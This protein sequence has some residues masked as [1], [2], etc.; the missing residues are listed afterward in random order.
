MNEN[1]TE[2]DVK[3]KDVKKKDVNRNNDS[4]LP[5]YKIPGNHYEFLSY[6][7]KKN[8]LG[9][10][11]TKF[12]FNIINPKISQIKYNVSLY[13]INQFNEEIFVK[14]FH[15]ISERPKSSTKRN[16]KRF[17]NSNFKGWPGKHNSQDYIN[18]STRNI[19]SL[20]TDTSTVDVSST[21]SEQPP[22]GS[23]QTWGTN[24]CFT[25]QILS[26][27]IGSGTAAIIQCTTSLTTILV[28]NMITFTGGWNY[29]IT[30][31]GISVPGAVNG[32]TSMTTI[33]SITLPYTITVLNPYSFY[34]CSNLKT[35]DSFN[36]SGVIVS[37]ILPSYI[38]S[39]CEYSFAAC[40][41]L[42]TCITSSN[43]SLTT[44]GVG[45]Y[46][47]CISTSFTTVTIP[48]SVTSIGVNAF[49][50][51]NYLTSVITYAFISNFQS[52]FPTIYNE[53]GSTTIKTVTFNY[54]GPI[55][56]N[57]CQSYT[58]LTSVTLT[59]VTSINLN[60]FESC[61]ALTTVTIPASVT[62]VGNNAFSGCTHLTSVITYAYISNFQTVFPTIY[63]ET[64]STTI[65][66][67]TFNYSGP[68]PVSACQSYTALTSVILTN[69]T[70][71]GDSAFYGCSALT[72][73]SMPNTITI[74]GD[75]A[76]YG[77]SDLKSTG[78]DS[79]NTALTSI[80]INV[81][82]LCK[83]T[84]F[85]T[86]TIPAIV[87]SIGV[88][89]F[90]GCT[91]LTSVITYAYISNFQTTFQTNPGTTGN[92]S[93]KTVT[94]NYYSN[95][96]PANACQSF[97][98]LTSVT[99]SNV[100]SIGSNAFDSCSA[101]TTVTI[102]ASVISINSN[103][104]NGCT[105]LTSCTLNCAISSLDASTI[106]SGCTELT[107]F[108]FGCAI[109][110]SYALNLT[111]ILTTVIFNSNVTSISTLAF[112]GCSTLQTV[113]IPANI[114]SIGDNAF[115]QCLLL[116]TV[117]I[118]AYISNFQTAFQTNS[119]ITGN[120]SI[121]TITFN[122]SDTIPDNACQSFTALKTI[123]LSNVNG[124][125]TSAFNGCTSLEHVSI[126]TTILSS[127]IGSYVFSGCSS[128]TYAEILGTTD[129]TNITDSMFEDCSSLTSVSNSTST[130][131]EFSTL[132]NITTI[133][134]GAFQGCGFKLF[135]MSNNITSIGSNLFNNC[136]NLTSVTLSTILTTIPNSAFNNCTSLSTVVNLITTTISN[137]SK[138][139]SIGDYAFNN[140]GL[141]GSI[142]F[143]NILTYV[144]NYAFSNCS[145]LTS[146]NIP[147]DTPISPTTLSPTTLMGIDTY[148]FLNCKLLASVNIPGLLGNVRQID[149]VPQFVTCISEGVFQ[150][151]GFTSID[152]TNTVYSSTNSVF[153]PKISSIGANAF[154]GCL[155]LLR[156]KLVNYSN[157]SN[158]I[159]LNYILNIDTNAFGYCNNL[160]TVTLLSNCYNSDNLLSQ[161]Q[162]T[163]TNAFTSC[164]SLQNSNNKGNVYTDVPILSYNIPFAS[165]PYPYVPSY[166]TLPDSLGNMFYVNVNTNIQYLVEYN[167]N[168]SSSVGINYPID[169]NSPYAYNSLV[170]VL[171]QGTLINTGFTFNGWNT[172]PTGLGTAYTTGTTF[173]I[174]S[175]YIVLYAQW[176]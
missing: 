156:I 130:T 114:I 77:C 169:T 20:N 133:G 3:K 166:F 91:Y 26:D 173:N 100:T 141:S 73:V 115:S 105:H 25:V 126:P 140:C 138:I 90:N 108:T 33:T 29:N 6:D 111:S 68:I 4:L 47:N 137:N 132:I 139:S 13:E 7:K 27:T 56:D 42:T 88:N 32:F 28:P 8:I 57:A 38:T 96:V 71:I 63:N 86:V 149:S 18:N 171:S 165:P 39:I 120:N 129:F 35:I 144:G 163:I 176:I 22:V 61:S 172:L 93:I 52:V 122:Y 78:F 15:F 102:P 9:K 170:T 117:T 67:V 79:S 119:G 155:S 60:A 85:T 134:S 121:T 34:G 95:P 142:Y 70:S 12:N 48:A 124:I 153:T 128:M 131:G 65:K 97:T 110:P 31:I 112:I 160:N 54:S 82:S 40:E 43:T 21:T 83:S 11:T 24:P 157:S 51:C 162:I 159:L 150:N 143:S 145:D 152:F 45:A 76:F 55:P 125:G 69:V 44:I 99:L 30:E 113:T 37:G 164:K 174:T 23:I 84:S 161:N 118:N 106:F 2:K 136:K 59:N 19:I 64:G 49:S 62:N 14:E 154:N 17:L 10:Y 87:T 1:L 80:G 146:V 151:C 175:N 127:N 53:T 107:T 147:T 158:T 41:S 72:S 109:V 116:T 89:A 148:A 103:A 123:N 75:Y 104:F 74:I 167:G 94:F 16:I 98:A 81:Y 50:E 92:N 36:T 66:T 58:A 46:S 135:N 168:C 101:L 5:T